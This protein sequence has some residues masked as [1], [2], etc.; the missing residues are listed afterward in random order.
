M[1]IVSQDF[2]F[3]KHLDI[4]SFLFLSI[5]HTHIYICIYL[6]KNN[7]FICAEGFAL[8]IFILILQCNL[9]LINWEAPDLRNYS[10]NWFPE[11]V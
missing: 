6:R 5:L 2:K 8:L 3:L 4:F 7:N 10:V 11:C 1:W 9:V